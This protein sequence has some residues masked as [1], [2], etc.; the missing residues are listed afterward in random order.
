MCLRRSKWRSSNLLFLIESQILAGVT[1]KQTKG[2]SFQKWTGS[3]AEKKPGDLRDLTPDNC[4]LPSKTS[5]TWLQTI[6]ELQFISL[7]FTQ[8]PCNN[9][10]M[11]KIIVLNFSY[12]Q[13]NDDMHCFVELYKGRNCVQAILD[14]LCCSPVSPSERCCGLLF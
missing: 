8:V 6:D 11:Y 5:E 10:L 14:L 2:L 9:R 4:P 7:T 12:E 3:P 13:S 1:E